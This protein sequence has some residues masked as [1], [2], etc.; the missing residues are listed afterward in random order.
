MVYCNG[1]AYFLGLVVPHLME[2]FKPFL[3]VML[4]NENANSIGKQ[5][6]RHG[7]LSILLQFMLVSKVHSL[8]NHFFSVHRYVKSVEDMKHSN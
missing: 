3:V 6:S 5:N 1:I 7:H 2:E 8:A 4:M